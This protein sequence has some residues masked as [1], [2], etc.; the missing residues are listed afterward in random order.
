MVRPANQFALPAAACAVTRPM[1]Q[2]LPD[3]PEADCHSHSPESSSLPRA[4]TGSAPA[5]SRPRLAHRKRNTEN[6][7][8]AFPFA[9]SRL[10]VTQTAGKAPQVHN[11]PGSTDLGLESPSY[12][13]SCPFVVQN[14]PNTTLAIIRENPCQS[15]AMASM[16]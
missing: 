1:L 5:D 12:F 4:L 16:P 13:S 9:A 14:T 11:I 10:R 2:G 7:P 15:V 3:H 8:C 6:Q